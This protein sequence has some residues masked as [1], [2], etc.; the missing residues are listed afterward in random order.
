MGAC[1]RSLWFE[2]QT[3]IWRAL[4]DVSSRLVS[5]CWVPTINKGIQMDTE[6]E[7][8][9]VMSNLWVQGCMLQI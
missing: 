7:G 2:N 1:R 6:G 5:T 4:H 8:L 9:K 3:L